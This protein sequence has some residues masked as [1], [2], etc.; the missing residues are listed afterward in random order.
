MHSFAFGF[1]CMLQMVHSRRVRQPVQPST[2][3]NAPDPANPL[4]TI[5][6]ALKLTKAMPSSFAAP[7]LHGLA[8]KPA[9]AHS[10]PLY[11]RNGDP[12]KH[13]VY[14]KSHET[15][16]AMMASDPHAIGK[17]AEQCSEEGCP[18]DDV[19]YI[20]HQL[21]EEGNDAQM[22]KIE[23]LLCDVKSNQMEVQKA[24]EDLTWGTPVPTS[25]KIEFAQKGVKFW[26]PIAKAPSQEINDAS[27][28]QP[29]DDDACKGDYYY[30]DEGCPIMEIEDLMEDMRDYPELAPTVAQ[31]EI[32]VEARKKSEEVLQNAIASL[33]RG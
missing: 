24:M 28:K 8:R 7:R 21:Q 17:L 11:S 2:D 16:I 29:R 10:A 25:S 5:L 9:L 33:A 22:K 1:A 6:L 13:H 32:A 3:Q 12:I 14:E 4:A 31:L 15:V 27:T 19:E 30:L 23:Q 20:I 26:I 18:F